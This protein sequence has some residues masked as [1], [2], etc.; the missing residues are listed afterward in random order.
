[1][2]T[3]QNLPS[4]LSSCT[5][6]LD[7]TVLCSYYNVSKYSPSKEL[8][9]INTNARIPSLSKVIS[10]SSWH[11]QR[12]CTWQLIAYLWVSYMLNVK[13]EIYKR[14]SKYL[15]SPFKWHSYSTIRNF[16]NEG[17]SEICSKLLKWGGHESHV[18]FKRFQSD[19]SSFYC[20]THAY[21]SHWIKF[22]VALSFQLNSECTVK[23]LF[24]HL[25][26]SI[27][28][29]SLRTRKKHVIIKMGN[30]KLQS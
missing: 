19:H 11:F 24:M 22:I 14:L 12:L 17:D 4:S 16:I 21:I 27:V 20:Y 9:V 3:K 13:A 15:Y 30:G 1:M 7:L 8:L 6:L 5:V 28:F 23:Q 29:K 2:N 10:R 26:L 18:Q 25:A